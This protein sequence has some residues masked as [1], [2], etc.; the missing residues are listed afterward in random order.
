MKS[1][2]KRQQKPRKHQQ[3]HEGTTKGATRVPRYNETPDP[4]YG[5]GLGSPLTA[6]YIEIRRRQSQPVL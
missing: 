6:F 5:T 2:K 1:S 3:E 4:L